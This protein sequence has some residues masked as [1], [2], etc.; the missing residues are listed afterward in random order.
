M[1]L[2]NVVATV[3]SVDFLFGAA[4]ATAFAKGV[5][6]L[7]RSVLGRASGNASSDGEPEQTTVK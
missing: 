1:T 5:K 4:T 7:F 3:L 6:G 2:E